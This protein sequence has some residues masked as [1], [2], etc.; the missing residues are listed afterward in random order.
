VR[1]LITGASGMLGQD[2]VQVARAA[3]WDAVPLT[4]ADLDITDADAVDSAIRAA[5]ADVVVNCAAWTDVDGAESALSDAVAVNGTGAGNVARAAHATGAWTVHISSDYVFDG[6][7]GSPYLESDPTG[8]VS[9]Y[10][11]SKLAGEEGVARSAPDRHTI[12]RSSWLFGAHGRCFPATILGLAAER[13]EL[14]VVDDQVGC[15]TFTEHLAT[16]LIEVAEQRPLGMLHLAGS[17]S[18]S[19]FDLAG[20]A[21]ELAGVRCHIT[22]AR[23]EDMP[24][25]AARPA[26]SVLVSE[27]AGAPALPPW[28]QGIEDYMTVWAAQREVPA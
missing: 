3:R 15:P 26:Y 20:R 1:I 27:R 17:G 13:D 12:V 7:K 5:G 24:R 28:Q 2:L 11:H 9:A 22:R 19:W 21:V 8:P 23:T 6:T 10:G 14:A 4:R 18:C 16:A 25:P